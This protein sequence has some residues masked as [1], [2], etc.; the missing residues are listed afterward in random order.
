[1][2]DDCTAVRADRSATW[3]PTPPP[4]APTV[5][6]AAP[7]WVLAPGL[8][9]AVVAGFAAELADGSVLEGLGLGLVAD[10]L[11]D[12]LARFDTWLLFVGRVTTSRTIARMATTSRASSTIRTERC[13]RRPP[14][15]GPDGTSYRAT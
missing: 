8:V 2:L 12:V 1:M 5:L 11:G 9:A 6:G 4:V 13:L 7:G 15:G 14:G 10:A 3:A